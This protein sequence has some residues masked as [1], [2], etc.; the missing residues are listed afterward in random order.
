[1]NEVFNPLS[2]VG[3]AAVDAAS[4]AARI[5]VDS[6]ERTLAVQLEYAKGAVKQATATAHAF[7]QVKDVQELFVLRARLAENAIENLMG[8]T[9]S[10]YEVASEAQ[11][12]YSR[13][14]E[15]RMGSFQQAVTQTVDKAAQSAPAGSDVAVAAMKSQ[16]AAATAAFDSFTKAARHMASFTDA[17]MTASRPAKSRK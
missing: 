15:E 16:L 5:S 8:Y 11:A 17:G 2:E 4:R 1:M 10:L 13:L 14:A 6:A 12:E 7:A 3:R 9:R